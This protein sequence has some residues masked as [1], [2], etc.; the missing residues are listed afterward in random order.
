MSVDQEA[1]ADL[2]I[3]RS[4]EYL[5][6]L[7]GNRRYGSLGSLSTREIGTI[8]H[9]LHALAVYDQRMFTPRTPE[10]PGQGG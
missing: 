1:L 3:V 10:T 4:V 9:A 8:M 5:N 7:L 6:N 2:R